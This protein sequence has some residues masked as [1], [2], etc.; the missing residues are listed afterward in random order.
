MYSHFRT[1]LPSVFLWKSP[2]PLHV[3]HQITT[4]DEFDNE[5]QPSNGNCQK[6]SW[7]FC[8]QS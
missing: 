2:L 3:E 4:S 8:Q 1:N 7:G 6:L 5:K